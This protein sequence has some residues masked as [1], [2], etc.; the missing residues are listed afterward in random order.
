MKNI[1]VGNLDTTTTESQLKELFSS[2]GAVATVTV[3]M[4][5]DTGTPRGFAFVEMADDAEAGAAIKAL[6]GT[7]L[8]ER[9]LSVNEARPKEDQKPPGRE[10]LVTR[11]HRRHRY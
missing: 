4:N 5:R 2:Y 10:P 1:Y 11:K 8:N 3:V 7:V 9:P 6:H